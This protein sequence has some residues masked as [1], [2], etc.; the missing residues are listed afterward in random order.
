LERL[1]NQSTGGRRFQRQVVHRMNRSTKERPDSVA[2]SPIGSCAVPR[3]VA[4][5]GDGRRVAMDGE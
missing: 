2:R 1:V 4:M 5:E 3:P